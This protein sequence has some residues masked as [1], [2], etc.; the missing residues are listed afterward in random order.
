MDQR[1]AKYGGMVVSSTRNYVANRTRLLSIGC[2]Y[3]RMTQTHVISALVQRRAELVGEIKHSQLHTRKL[4]EDLDHLDATIRQF[5][6]DYKVEDITPKGF[7]P[8]SDWAGRGEMSRV[9]LDVLRRAKEPMTTQE[10]AK[11]IMKARGLPVNDAKLLRKMTK[12]AGVALRG[13]RGNGLVRSSQGNGLFMMW[14]M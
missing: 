9:V 3:S 12:R 11:E 5:D 2:Y 1:A 8:P 13:Q 10:L 4:L 7:R 14:T 6:L